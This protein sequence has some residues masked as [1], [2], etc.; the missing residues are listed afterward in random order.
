MSTQDAYAPPRSTVRDVSGGA[1]L[2]SDRVINA[3]RKTRPWV[4]LIAILGFIFT[5][6]MVLSGVSMLL[7]GG[8]IGMS[9]SM[10]EEMMGGGFMVAMGVFYLIFAVVYFFL[11][12][13]LLRYAGAIKR[14]V[15]SLNIADVE[16][17]VENQASFWKLAGILTLLSIILGILVM[18]VGIV[19]AVWLGAN[20]G[21]L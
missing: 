15:N 13:Y 12:L 6:L 20:S 18:V 11:S 9:S 2:T 16:S 5:A 10:P 3:L 14:A 21:G 1:G 7:G 19:S 8:S 4:L 17:A